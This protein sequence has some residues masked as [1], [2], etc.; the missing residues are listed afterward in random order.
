MSCRLLLGTDR[1]GSEAIK[2]PTDYTAARMPCQRDPVDNP[3]L[4]AAETSEV[5]AFCPSPSITPV[6]RVGIRH[7]LE[8]ADVEMAGRSQP[9]HDIMILAAHGQRGIVQHDVLHRHLS[10]GAAG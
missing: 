1:E 5:Q 7:R 2:G 6:P 10:A 9:E 4:R 3:D 8:R